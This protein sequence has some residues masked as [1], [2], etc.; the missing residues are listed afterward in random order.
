[1]AKTRRQHKTNHSRTSKTIGS[2]AEVWHGTA[3]R[4]NG[5]LRKNDLLKNKHGEIVSRIKSK[6][7]NNLKYLRKYGYIPKKGVF[8]LFSNQF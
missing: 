3:L 5:G 7:K 2:R 1:M 8:K 6:N 4:T